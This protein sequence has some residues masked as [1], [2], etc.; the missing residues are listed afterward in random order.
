M[1]WPQ[2]PFLDGDLGGSTDVPADTTPPVDCC[3]DPADVPNRVPDPSVT[4]IWQEA[5]VGSLTPVQDAVDTTG[6][7]SMDVDLASLATGGNLLIAVIT[8][9]SVHGDPG[10][11]LVDDYGF[12]AVED[13]ADS[14]TGENGGTSQLL[15][16]IAD[17]T[18]QNF[19]VTFGAG[20]QRRGYIAEFDGTAVF[21][22]SVNSYDETSG[23]SGT[24][25]SLVIAGSALLLVV[26]D[27]KRSVGAVGDITLGD[28]F[29][30]IDDGGVGGASDK[31]NHTVGYRNVT[32][33]TYQGSWSAGVTESGYGGLL[34]SFVFPEDEGA[35]IP[36][37]DG[38]ADEDDATYSETD[39]PNVLL[40]DL[41]GP[42]EI[43]RTRFRIG[44]DTSGAKSYTIS[45][46]NE[47]DLSDE[48]LIATLTFTGTGSYTAQD[49][50]EQWLPSGAYRYWVLRGPDESRRV[51]EWELYEGTIATNHTHD[52]E[53]LTTTETDTD[54][55]LKPDGTGGV[56]W[57]TDEG[58]GVTD[59]GALTGLGDDDHPQ[60]RLESADHSHQT[61][62]LQAGQ[63]DHGAALTGLTDDDHTQYVLK[64]LGGKEVVST[65]AASG[66]SETLD[67]ADG[68]V[69]DV[70]LTD[71]C[72][73]SLTGATAGVSCFMEIWLRQD[74]SGN[75]EVTW[76]GSVVWV[77]GSAP[78]LQTDPAAVDVVVLQ[79]LDGG[80]NWLGGV[81]SGTGSSAPL[82]DD[83]PLIES[84][85][86][87]AGVSSE[88]SRSDHVHPEDADTGGEDT[89]FTDVSSPG[90]SETIDCSLFR[91][92]R[93]T[94]DDD[95]AISLTG[96]AGG[97]A[98][99]LTILLR[100][101]GTGGWTVTWPAEVFWP[102]GV[103]PT[104]ATDP[105]HT[106][107]VDLISVDGTNWLGVLNGAD[108][109]TPAPPVG[110][111]SYWPMLALSSA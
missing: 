65:V 21:D 82:S 43:V 15:W 90:S 60:Y 71:D 80:T 62:G 54:L 25:A 42:Y 37:G 72:T 105:D 108:H 77:G 93:L 70:T 86:G 58:G 33:G 9:R 30:E 81:G 7:S 19:H 78:V 94:L 26:F 2:I 18:E 11:N 16:K 89:S 53:T 1:R 73:I 67:L 79:T 57:D 3:E 49:I 41:G 51:F 64:T 61:T 55:V 13:L 45:G 85:A 35:W 46:A 38:A 69:H 48:V 75:R 4:F 47:A 107:W 110:G 104:L 23:T 102:G 39:G 29:T 27:I 88:A 109:D 22:D 98:H 10:S 100:Q 74:G 92:Y 8:A 56:H 95:C 84:G 31:P 99:R 96:A 103:T 24:V 87:S 76:P 50:E 12:V 59:H 68:N 40:V 17:G 5:I 36:G 91:V 28:S 66:S 52:I 6:L 97:E 34:A 106:D 32:A 101:D 14:G 44:T 20:E 111:G 63:L 83:V